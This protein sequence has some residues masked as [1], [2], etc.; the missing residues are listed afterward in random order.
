MILIFSW[1][2]ERFV[3][4]EVTPCRAL[5]VKSKVEGSVRNGYRRGGGGRR[6]GRK[7]CGLFW[8]KLLPESRPVP[9][10]SLLRVRKYESKFLNLPQGWKVQY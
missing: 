8:A 2:T 6:E 1:K 10:L 4:P 3:I 5:D 7:S 9:G